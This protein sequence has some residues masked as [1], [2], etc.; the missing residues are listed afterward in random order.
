MLGPSYV[1]HVF[2][3]KVELNAHICTMNGFRNSAFLPM[4]VVCVC[5]YVSHD[6][7]TLRVNKIIFPSR[8]FHTTNGNV[9]HKK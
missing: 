8:P 2:Q 1:F 9:S 6:I 3:P 4:D 5:C 7:D